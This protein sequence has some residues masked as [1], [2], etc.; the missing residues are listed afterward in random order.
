[1]S[2]GFSVNPEELKDF[3]G[4][5]DGHRSSASRIAELVAMADVGDKSWGLVGLF[6]KEQ[7]TQ[8]LGDLKDTMQAM[9]DGLQSGSD[10]FRDTA[11]GYAQQEEALKQIL[12]GIQ[13]ERS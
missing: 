7:Y 6:V 5:L 8:M 1:M 2:G 4:K 3:A 13:V 10:K 12:D 11:E 9:Q